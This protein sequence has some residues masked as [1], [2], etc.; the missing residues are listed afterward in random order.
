VVDGRAE[1]TPESVVIARGMVATNDKAPGG[2][3]V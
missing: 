3:E 1:A 2:Y